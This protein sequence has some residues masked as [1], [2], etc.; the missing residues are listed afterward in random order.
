MT[1]HNFSQLNQQSFKLFQGMHQNVNSSFVG[2]S[3]KSRF[4]S[5]KSQHNKLKRGKS[6]LLLAKE[7]DQADSS[8]I[9]AISS[10]QAIKSQKLIN[11]PMSRN[12]HNGSHMISRKKTLQNLER[13]NHDGSKL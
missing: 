11:L 4:L 1:S 2:K 6:N 9:G 10:L 8:M 3:E 7:G 12:Q 5:P 13:R